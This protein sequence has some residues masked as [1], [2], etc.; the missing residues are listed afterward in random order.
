MWPSV[1]VLLRRE[2]NG[3]W[4]GV[5]GCAWERAAGARKLNSEVMFTRGP[6]ESRQDRTTPDSRAGR[7]GR[8]GS[9][10]DGLQVLGGSLGVP[11]GDSNLSLRTRPPR[12]GPA[13]QGTGLMIPKS[14]E[15][16]WVCEGDGLPNEAPEGR[17]SRAGSGSDGPQ[18][19]GGS[20]RSAQEPSKSVPLGQLPDRTIRSSEVILGGAQ[21]VRWEAPRRDYAWTCA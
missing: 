18:V 14:W 9:G 11:K 1:W 20:F 8:A 13:G 16:S 2:G 4:S 6:L 5:G 12:A 19:L 7:A 21:M 17:A 10:S 3:V 15:G